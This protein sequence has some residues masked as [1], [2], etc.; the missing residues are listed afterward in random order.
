MSDRNF[1]NDERAV[2]E[3]IDLIARLIARDYKD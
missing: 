2:D 3:L 1:T